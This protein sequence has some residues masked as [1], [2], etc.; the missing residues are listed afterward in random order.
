MD[1]ASRDSAPI[2]NRP[3]S[4]DTSSSSS[5]S[6]G[7]SSAPPGRDAAKFASDIAR[8]KMSRDLRAR[9]EMSEGV[10]SEK[11]GNS[12]NTVERLR[13]PIFYEINKLGTK[14]LQFA[15]D[16][17][18]KEGLKRLRESV[19]FSINFSTPSPVPN[20]KRKAFFERIKT[21]INSARS[22]PEALQLIEEI[23]KSEKVL[24]KNAKG[25]SQESELHHSI[26]MFI[27]RIKFVKQQMALLNPERLQEVA[28]G[29]SAFSS[30]EWHRFDDVIGLLNR[31][32]ALLIEQLDNRAPVA[33]PW[34]PI[35]AVE[36]EEKK[37]EKRESS[38]VTKTVVESTSRSIKAT[39]GMLGDLFEKMKSRIFGED[40]SA[41]PASPSD[42]AQA[43]LSQQI[44][45]MN[46]TIKELRKWKREHPSQEMIEENTCVVIYSKALENINHIETTTEDDFEIVHARSAEEREL[47]FKKL[48]LD[49]PKSRDPIEIFRNLRTYVNIEGLRASFENEEDSELEGYLGKFTIA[50]CEELQKELEASSESLKFGESYAYKEG[51]ENERELLA[52]RS[53]LILKMSEA[54]ALKGS[55]KLSSPPTAAI[56]SSTSS[57]T[58]EG[59]TSRMLE[60]FP[61]ELFHNFGTAQQ[62]YEYA[63]FQVKVLQK[64]ILRLNSLR[65]RNPKEELALTTNLRL[66]QEECASCLAHK[67]A[68]AAE[69]L[70]HGT[71][72]SAQRQG[73]FDLILQPFDN[74]SEQYKID[75]IDGAI[76]SIDCARFGAPSLFQRG[77]DGT[78]TVSFRS[79]MM[80][81]PAAT[82]PLDREL[83]AIINSWDIS[84][85]REQH[86]REGLIGTPEGNRAA[87]ERYRDILI[88]LN[89]MQKPLPP[90]EIALLCEKY[91]IEKGALREGVIRKM[92]RGKAELELNEVRKT[93]FK[94]IHHQAFKHMMQRIVKAQAYLRTNPTPTIKGLRCALYPELTV[95]FEVLGRVSA[96]PG[97]DIAV[98]IETNAN[99]VP[100]IVNRSIESIISLAQKHHAIS[101]KE[102][103]AIEDLIAEINRTGNWFDL[104]QANFLSD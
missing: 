48:G 27:E 1:P 6:T 99:G 31:H 37:E 16:S 36:K 81:H 39:S 4:G 62:K 7:S 43:Q 95:I 61:V 9:K 34:T 68:L 45:I 44:A 17:I 19:E 20:P 22:Y 10:L 87:L 78:I 53:A 2:P 102:I 28:T 35:T 104:A 42:I 40:G 67:E 66:W 29:G 54:L 18:D 38:D 33:G 74:H 86:I 5:R 41:S 13:A 70:S 25:R 57:G 96:F 52:Q 72:K 91:H 69:L 58:R 75:P 100:K 60:D 103:A 15:K 3:V 98:K 21:S 85:I 88:D 24:L 83:V 71:T 50:F 46:E 76:K 59:I 8:A 32:Q 30:I 14:I 90:P 11:L 65:S 97:N 56:S 93:Q 94:L 12:V 49:I 92:I 101:P 26:N 84:A 82:L 77:A 73:V 23:C 63:A 51:L 55:A 89:R 47:R 79:I 80:D 64:E